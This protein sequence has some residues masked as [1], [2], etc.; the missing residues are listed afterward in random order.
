LTPENDNFG[1]A[2]WVYEN[3]RDIANILGPDDHYGE[4]AGPGIQKNPHGFLTRHFFV[5]PKHTNDIGPLNWLVDSVQILRPPTLYDGPFTPW[6]ME[7]MIRFCRGRVEA[8]QYMEGFVIL[9]ESGWRNKWTL[10]DGHK[11]QDAS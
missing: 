11:G 4:W 3:A 1:F 6:V 7:P 5:F 9:H 8:G 10:N 2:K